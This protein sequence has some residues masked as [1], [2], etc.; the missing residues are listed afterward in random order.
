M[1]LCSYIFPQPY[2]TK[3]HFNNSSSSFLT[4]FFIP[5]IYLGTGISPTYSCIHHG[6]PEPRNSATFGAVSA[7][8]PPPAFLLTKITPFSGTFT[9]RRWGCHAG[10]LAWSLQV[11]PLGLSSCPGLISPALRGFST[12]ILSWERP[13]NLVYSLPSLAK[14]PPKAE[15]G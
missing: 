6:L 11:L 12:S 4:L 5:G 8:F 9:T 7:A 14:F 3:F 15:Q 10:I 2:I 13:Q 1:P